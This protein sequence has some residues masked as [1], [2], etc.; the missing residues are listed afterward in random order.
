CEIPITLT[1]VDPR[2]PFS[3]PCHVILANLRGCA[4]RSASPVPAGV[5]V[6]I[7]GLPT[8]KAVEA[9]IVHCISLGEFEKLWLLGLAINEESNV[10]GI[11][12]VPQDWSRQG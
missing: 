7:E 4:A 3:Q 8:G 1:S 11:E 9:R 10:W 12:P 5:L 6:L 2:H